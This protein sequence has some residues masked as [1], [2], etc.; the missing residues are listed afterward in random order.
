MT[1]DF[2]YSRPEIYKQ[3]CLFD[4]FSFSIFTAPITP[5]IVKD[6]MWTSNLSFVQL[7]KR[8][9]YHYIG[10]YYGQTVWDQKDD[11]NQGVFYS[12]L[13]KQRQIWN[14]LI[15]IEIRSNPLSEIK[16]QR[17]SN[18]HFSIIPCYSDWWKTHFLHTLTC[19]GRLFACSGLSMAPWSAIR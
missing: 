4:I 12:S 18:S 11:A 19:L 16:C 6:R 9:N 5:Q 10:N 1:T 13:L 3:F 14:I 17:G 2:Q 8:D 7:L 15:S